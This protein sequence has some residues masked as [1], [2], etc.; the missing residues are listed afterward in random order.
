M[1]D[2]SIKRGL[3]ICNGMVEKFRHI[4]VLFV[5]IPSIGNGMLFAT[6]KMYM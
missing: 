4:A 6:I 5:E 1:Y 2:E 3:N